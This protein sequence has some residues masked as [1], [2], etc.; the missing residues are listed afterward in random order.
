MKV[1]AANYE[2]IKKIDGVKR[3]E[4]SERY[5]EPKVAVKNDANV[6]ATGIYNSQNINEKGE[7]MVVA[8]LDT[9]L[10]YSHEAFAAMPE[11]PAWDKNYVATK[12]AE[13]GDGFYAKVTADKAYYNAKIPYA[14][15]YADDDADVYPSYSTHGTHVAGIVA[16]KS[17]YVVNKETEETFIGVA[18]QAQL[19]I[20]KVFTDNLDS[21][22]LGG[23]DTIDIISAVS[24]CVALGVD[25]INMSL[26]SSAGFA[27]ESDNE[28]TGKLTNEIYARVKEA[29]ISLVVAASNDY[30]S[31]FGGGNG[32]NLA[33][34]PDSGT[35]GSPSTY[36][37][38]LS[39]ASI[40]GERSRYIETS[41][42]K[43]FF[44][45]E[46][47]DLQKIEQNNFF[48]DFK[49]YLKQLGTP[50]TPGK[51]EFTYVHVSGSGDDVCYRD[52]VNAYKAENPGADMT[53]PEVK[54]QVL[55]GKIVLVERGTNSFEDKAHI[56]AEYGAIA[57]IIYNNIDGDITMSMGNKWH[58]PT[59]SISRDD[60]RELAKKSQGSLFFD[61]ENLAGPF[62]SDFSSWGP[63]P[64]LGIK[65]EITAH[66]GNIKSA[67]PGRDGDEY[68][69]GKLS[70]TSMA[71]P[72]LCGIVVLIRQYLKD[73][74]GDELTEKQIKN[75][76]NQLMMSTAGIAINEEN[77]PYSPRKQGAGLADIGRTT[78]TKGY[79]TVDGSDRSKL[80][81]GDDPT[82]SG[83]YTMN[84][85]VVNMSETDLVY[86]FSLVGMTESVSTSDD[87]FVAETPHIL[88]NTFK[89]EF[90]GG[91]GNVSGNKITVNGN[92]SGTNANEWNSVKVKVTY[93]L[94]ADDRKY[95]DDRFPYGMYVEGFIK[96]AN[97]DS[98][99]VSL[100][101]PFLAFYG[102]WTEAPMFD[103][104]YYEVETTAHDPSISDDDKVKA[105]YYATTPYGKYFYNYMIP[106]GTYLYDIDTSKYS[107]IPATEEKIAIS[108]TLGAID[109]I[110][111]VLAGLLR[112][113][114]QMKFTLTDKITG[115][116]LWNHIDYN[117][118]KS[119][120]QGGSPLPYYDY[121]KLDSAKVGLV[122]N[123][124][125]EFKMSGKL[126]YGEDG[127][128]TLSGGEALMQKDFAL[129]LMRRCREHGIRIALETNGV[130][131]KETYDAVMPYVDLFLYDYKATDPEVHKAYV[132][133]DNR[134]I[135]ENLRYLHDSGAR[136][137]VRCPI[138]PGVNDNQTHFDAIAQLTV[139]LPKLVGAEILPYHKLGVSKAKRIDSEYQ[140]FEMVDASV[141]DGWKRYIQSKGGRLVNVE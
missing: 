129:E 61:E 40:S 98:Q 18:P 90:E 134:R 6:Y 138:I 120:S 63:T 57:C 72:N 51:N 80:E 94:S 25:V 35:V 95:I 8:V 127:G 66:G 107:E 48:E 54:K 86:D 110:S 71:C 47:N 97:A 88:G 14:Y 64:S 52:F 44:Y 58:I 70:G 114:K 26:G 59:I 92:A 82:R 130:H 101:A 104:T 3:V 137:L 55:K 96:L 126:D 133:C 108:D 22:G 60:G 81:L 28:P 113:A 62:M 121:L 77:N 5:A 84:F 50:L 135:L 10:D 39:V 78:T 117:A 33:S 31:G 56:A 11:H 20:C 119:F 139:Q 17:D 67:I 109:G 79:V 24:D 53:D 89:A 12:I 76:T 103:K 115:K 91:D 102:D 93:T 141:S 36:D 69:Y 106:L 105:D 7:G 124:Q 38:A 140:E 125:Y 116:E 74:Y 118:L 85:N 112:G 4:F 49:A 87:K 37:A 111:V 34:N 27:T 68:R 100:N 131:R 13:A 16:G 46:S 43:M 19:V 45:N 99:G 122:N 1:D 41:D 32:T 9:G 30:S 65:P 128:V 75:L 15:D 132:G 42:G 136:V 2:A 29:G 21:D 23:A 123:R 73:G 83:I